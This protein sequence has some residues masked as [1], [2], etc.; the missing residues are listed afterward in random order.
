[1]TAKPLSL[2]TEA[3][4]R[5]RPSAV[6]AVAE[7]LQ[8]ITRVGVTIEPQIDAF[9]PDEGYLLDTNA[10]STLRSY[11]YGTV[12]PARRAALRRAL[13]AAGLV[14]AVV[15]RVAWRTMQEEDWAEAWKEHYEIEHIGRVVIR[16][17][18]L[19]YKDRQPDDV[20]ISIDPGMAF[21][22]GQHATT[23]M[24]L[25]ALQ[26]LIK[27]GDFVLD[28]GTGSGIL[29]LTAASM[30]AGNVLAVDTEEQA[31]A[32]A[33][34]NAAGNNLL[35]Q[36]AIAHGSIESATIFGAFDIILAN[37]NAATL[38]SLAP[39]I[40]GVLK[41]GGHLIAGGIIEERRLGVT[42]DLGLAGLQV[43]R[44]LEEGDWRTLVCRK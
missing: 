8:E 40:A 19:E 42:A 38:S 24:C 10:P 21:G 43:E 7:L 4:I 26:E 17:A 34:F 15:G 2:W 39:K 6:E 20:V 23:R 18:W 33:R 27:P 25:Q 37:I 44:K 16:P 9:G 36:I 28:L 35:G 30:G 12:P 22:T 29:A 13:R 5:V 1:M 32:A 3:S 11:F 31:V 14:E 41:P